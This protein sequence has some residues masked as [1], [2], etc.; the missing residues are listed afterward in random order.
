MYEKMLSEIK[1]D[2]QLLEG[3][4]KENRSGGWSTNLE[5]PMKKRIAELKSLVYDIEIKRSVNL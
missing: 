5:A 1:K 4:V 2:I 3:W